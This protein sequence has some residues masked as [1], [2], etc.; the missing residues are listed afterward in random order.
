MK[1]VLEHYFSTKTKHVDIAQPVERCDYNA[2]FCVQV[3]LSH[4]VKKSL[5]KAMDF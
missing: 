1:F 2:R 4:F 5:A 3:V